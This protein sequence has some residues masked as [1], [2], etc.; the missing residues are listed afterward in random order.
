MTA[1]W[2]EPWPTRHRT[3]RA[4][5]ARDA[6]LAEGRVPQIAL[7]RGTRSAFVPNSECLNPKQTRILCWIADGCQLRES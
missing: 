6:R 3:R 1:A 5:D 4:Y 7:R 2:S